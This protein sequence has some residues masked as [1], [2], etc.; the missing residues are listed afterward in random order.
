MDDTCD[1][2]GPNEPKKKRRAW[3]SNARPK[4]LLLRLT[5]EEHSEIT[6]RAKLARL[7]AAQYL[8]HSGLHG[9]PP[10]M[11]ATLPLDGEKREHLLRAL[12]ELRRIGVTLNALRIAYQSARLTGAVPPIQSELVEALKETI[13]LIGIS[14]VLLKDYL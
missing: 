7:S 3:R 5:E 14:V 1:L 4:H 13:S 9:R 10:A 11:R 12:Y 2:S 8:T 6:R